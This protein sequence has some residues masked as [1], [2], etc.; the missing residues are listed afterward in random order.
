[1]H[2]SFSNSQR[3]TYVRILICLTMLAIVAISYK[4]WLNERNY[5]L[6]PVFDFIPAITAPFDW[7]Q[8]GLVAGL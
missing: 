5:P 7:I 8:L 6:A 4:L 2:L 3:I 1:M